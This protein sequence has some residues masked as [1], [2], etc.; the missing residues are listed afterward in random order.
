[1]AYPYSRERYLSEQ[2]GTNAATGE[3]CTRVSPRQNLETS[4][5]AKAEEQIIRED[6]ATLL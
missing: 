6:P 1:M 3:L 5:E 4:S 2:S